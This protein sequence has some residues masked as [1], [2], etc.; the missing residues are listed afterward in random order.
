[1]KSKPT[2]CFSVGKSKVRCSAVGSKVFR[3]SGGFEFDPNPARQQ[4][5]LGP[6]LTRRVVNLLNQIPA[7]L[8]SL[9]E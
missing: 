6:S 8:M 1:M 4:G 3:R 2:G 7:E 9:V 5:N